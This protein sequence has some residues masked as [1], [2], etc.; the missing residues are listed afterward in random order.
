VTC[1]VAYVATVFSTFAGA[2]VIATSTRIVTYLITCLALPVLR[3]RRDLTAPLFEL[4][5]G[6]PI[7]VAC[8]AVLV[9][10][11]LQ[12]SWTELATLVGVSAAG[13]LPSWLAAFKF[14]LAS[15]K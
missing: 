9:F 12:S 11:L 13:L 15:T 1:G 2:L 10:L 4:R 6:V 5:A 7:A 8:T 3:G 14:K